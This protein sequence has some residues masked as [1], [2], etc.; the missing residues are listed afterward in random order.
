LKTLLQIQALD[1][2]IENCKQR[3]TEI[4]KQKDKFNIHKNQLAAE[5]KEAEDRCTAI[6]LS[7]REAESANEQKQAQIIKYEQQLMGVKKN[8]EYQA[9]LHEIDGLK[10]QI[11]QNEEK[12]L[13]S[14][15]DLEEAQAKLTDDKKRIATE[16]ARIDEQCTEI[17]VELEEA[18]TGRKVLEEERIPLTATADSELMQQYNRIRG[19]LAAGRAIVPLSGESCGGCHMFVR[20]QIVNEVLAGKVHP[21]QNCSRLMYD[22]QTYEASS[23]DPSAV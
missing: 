14:M 6:E 5:L 22:K 17:D 13:Q 18:I 11:G 3:E 23:A 16:Q 19:R 20:P 4:P 2:R 7:Q 12:I 1:L 15:E 21:C 10:K 9:L 8:E